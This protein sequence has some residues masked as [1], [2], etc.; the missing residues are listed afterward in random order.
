MVSREYAVAMRGRCMHCGDASLECELLRS[1]WLSSWRVACSARH[2]PMTRA[3]SSS[4]Y[5]PLPE[6]RSYKSPPP[7]SSITCHARSVCRA[8]AV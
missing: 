3:A 6:T 1:A 2:V 5:L 8:R 4:G 7:T